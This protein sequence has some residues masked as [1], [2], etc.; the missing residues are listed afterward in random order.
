[1]K[2]P[3]CLGLLCLG[4]STDR[5]RTDSMSSVDPPITPTKGAFPSSTYVVVNAVTRRDLEVAVHGCLLAERAAASENTG[6]F[7]YVEK[8]DSPSS[9]GR[10][11]G[12]R[13]RVAPTLC[14]ENANAKTGTWNK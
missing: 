3:V 6:R 8:N 11:E 1:M 2:L 12:G 4:R 14:N 5:P 10:K 7:V 13:A 9:V